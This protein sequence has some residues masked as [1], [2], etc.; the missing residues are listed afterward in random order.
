MPREPGFQ[1]VQARRFHEIAQLL[2]PAAYLLLDARDEIGVSLKRREMLAIQ[3]RNLTVR[4]QQRSK[5]AAMRVKQ[6]TLTYQAPRKR[7]VQNDFPSARLLQSVI[8]VAAMH[9]YHKI[10]GITFEKYQP[11]PI[12][13]PGSEM[14]R[15]MKY[16]LIRQ[17]LK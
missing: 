16:E 7:V 9:E 8:N 13:W 2:Q 15:Y 12:Y 1:P 5:A 6:G 11:F 17:P 10:L 4:T 3:Q 14:L